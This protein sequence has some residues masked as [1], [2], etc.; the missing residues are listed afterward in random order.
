MNLTIRNMN[1]NYF[2]IY[3]LYKNQNYKQTENQ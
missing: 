2:Y 3:A 1:Q